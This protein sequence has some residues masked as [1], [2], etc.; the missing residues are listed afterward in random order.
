MRK[1]VV[2]AVL[3]IIGGLV[4]CSTAVNTSDDPRQTVVQFFNAM[5]DNDTASLAH[6][7]DFRTMMNSAGVD[8]A[9]S[10]T[11]APR[12]FNAPQD[13][14]H[15]LVDGGLTKQRWFSYQRIVGNATQNNDSAL[16]EVSFINKDINKQYL[17]YFGLRRIQEQWKIYTFKATPK[18]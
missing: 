12:V 3:C 5:S 15:D 2:L 11:D 13:I 18:E 9:L 6:Y 7:I 10:T 8:Y 14:L 16:V 4:A 17:T 1:L